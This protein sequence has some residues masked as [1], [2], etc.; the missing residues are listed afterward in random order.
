[1]VF[2]QTVRFSVTKDLQTIAVRSQSV[3]GTVSCAQNRQIR[4]KRDVKNPIRWH[5]R[6]HRVFAAIKLQKLGSP[7]SI[8][9]VY[10]RVSVRT[11]L[12]YILC[13]VCCIL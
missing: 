5:A 3:K 13:R 10:V 7:D 1:M 4:T 8:V 6:V 11:L 2:S 9:F 12:F